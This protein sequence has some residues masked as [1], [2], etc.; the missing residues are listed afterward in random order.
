[1]AAVNLPRE[2]W[3]VD[4]WARDLGQAR[5]LGTYRRSCRAAHGSRRTGWGIFLIGL[6]LLPGLAFAGAAQAAAR[7]AVLGAAGAL[8][9]A[10]AALIKSAPREKA[11]WIFLY[12][13][14]I[15]QVIDG[16]AA[17]RV[18]PWR[19]LG[20]VLKEYSA[21]TEDTE[22]SLS[23]VHVAGTD[24]TVIT[25]GSGYGG[26]VSQLER[27]VDEVT[28]AMRLPAAI[29]RF[30]TGAPVSFG[31]LSVS[32][33][34]I[35]WDGGAERAAWHDIRSVRVRPYQIDLNAGAWKTGQ[36]IGLADVPDSCVAVK[37]IQEAAARRG[38]RRKGPPAAVTPPAAG[39]VTAAGTAVL[40]QADVRAVLGW[41]V[42]TVTGPGTGTQAARFRGGGADLSLT[43]RERHTAD[44]AITRLF[45]RAVP[46]IGEQAWLIN[47]DRTLVVLAG[48]AAVRLDLH[49]LP[50][51]AR[52]GVLIPLARLAA[53][54]LAVPPGH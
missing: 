36:V 26:A 30:G 27:D 32:Q 47:S 12:E 29:E 54:R 9:A 18:I 28:V 43:I 35:A 14:G 20:H 21:G 31:G 19:L 53:A 15:A 4:A 37:L 3:N 46:G 42:E 7:A 22:P 49:G 33:N 51:S 1:M 48:P 6:G 41:P 50:R 34:E 17:P 23:A 38:V 2:Q 40:S 44:R 8:V 11:D 39:H 16:E 25:A 10:G 52:T 45:G 13:G 24:G 5:K